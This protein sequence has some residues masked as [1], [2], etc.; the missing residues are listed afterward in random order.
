MQSTELTCFYYNNKTILSNLKISATGAEVWLEKKCQYNVL[1]NKKVKVGSDQKEVPQFIVPA[2]LLCSLPLV[3]IETS[4]MNTLSGKSCSFCSP[5]L[6]S[7]NVV[8]FHVFS[9]SPGVYVGTLNLIA[10]IPGPSIL[11]FQ[12]PR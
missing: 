2:S 11:T 6:L 7:E 10:P 8:M 3:L 12:V 9:F 1:S 5:S 4:R